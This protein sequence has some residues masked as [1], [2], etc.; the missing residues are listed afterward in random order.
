MES[1]DFYNS[2]QHQPVYR[3]DIIKHVIDSTVHTD[4]GSKQ[5]SKEKIIL[6]T[7]ESNNINEKA[8][9]MSDLDKELHALQ[10][11]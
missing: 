6:C 1:L 10:A 3:D 4:A 2:N 11:S 7:Y 8:N 9:Q 5:V